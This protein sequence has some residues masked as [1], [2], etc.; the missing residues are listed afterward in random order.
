MAEKNTSRVNTGTRS[1]AQDDAA[2]AA[3]KTSAASEH[4]KDIV[5][6]AGGTFIVEKNS[7]GMTIKTRIA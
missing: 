3:L 7:F 1:K 6:E 5:D 4:G 2:L